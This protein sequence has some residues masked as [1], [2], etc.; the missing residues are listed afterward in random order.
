MGFTTILAQFLPASPTP[1]S[2]KYN[3]ESQLHLTFS[4]SFHANPADSLP[5]R[6][7]IWSCM[8]QQKS[9]NLPF[10]FLMQIYMH[11][12]YFYC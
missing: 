8:F 10:S 11:Q 6:R 9:A 7:I 4:L 1:N 12:N 5:L 3:L 2:G